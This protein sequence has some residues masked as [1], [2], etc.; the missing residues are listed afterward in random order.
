MCTTCLATALHTCYLVGVSRVLLDA[1]Q[2][3]TWL[4]DT[5]SEPQMLITLLDVGQTCLS[6]VI[7]QQQQQAFDSHTKARIAASMCHMAA[8]L[9]KACQALA[10]EPQRQIIVKVRCHMSQP[11]CRAKHRLPTNVNASSQ[12]GV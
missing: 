2:A 12:S 9:Q 4:S 3:Q 5:I 6:T 8:T 1:V 7:T 10:E 11:E